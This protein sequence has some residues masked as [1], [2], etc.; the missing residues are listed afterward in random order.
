MRRPPSASYS[1]KVVLLHAAIV[2]DVA[3]SAATSVGAVSL[4]GVE[5]TLCAA[6]AQV[7]LAL[8]LLSALAATQ[9]FQLGQVRRLLSCEVAAALALLPVYAIASGGAG[10][11]AAAGTAAA[12]ALAVVAQLA[13]ML[14]YAALVRAIADVGEARFYEAS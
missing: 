13:G 4:G 10:A 7:C 11:A 2:A 12:A 1:C 3:L 14:Y 5:S 9:P 8:L 6:C